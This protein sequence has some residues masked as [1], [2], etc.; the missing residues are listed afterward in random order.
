MASFKFV[1]WLLFWLF[2]SE[3]FIF[4]WDKGNSEKN[5]KKHGVE[6]KEVEEVFEQK[7]AIP[8]GEQIAPKVEEKRFGI[9]GPTK[10]GRIL[11]IVF[12]IREGKVRPISARPAHKKEKKQYEEGLRKI[13]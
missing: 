9:I 10:K 4:E 13:P 1:E 11:Q 12:T 6:I 3:L 2:E 5:E 8:L 7:S